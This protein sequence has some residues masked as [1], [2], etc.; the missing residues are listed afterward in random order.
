MHGWL[1][2]NVGSNVKP[3]YSVGPFLALEVE[4]EVEVEQYKSPMPYTKF[5]QYVPGSNIQLE[6]IK[7]LW[8]V[9]MNDFFASI[10]SLLCKVAS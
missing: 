10:S 2:S 8:S 6:D 4:I 3:R 9:S 5:Q 1:T 7:P